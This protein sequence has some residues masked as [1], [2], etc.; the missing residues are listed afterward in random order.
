MDDVEKKYLYRRIAGANPHLVLERMRV[1]G[2]WPVGKGLPPAPPEEVEERKKID[3]ELE[4][5]RAR[6]AGKGSAADVELALREERKRRWEESKKR[7]SE[8]KKLREARAAERRA[9]WNKQKKGLLVFA[10]EGV[11]AG[12]RGLESDAAALAKRGLPVLHTPPELAAAIGISI[13][14]L[15]WL[16]FHRGGAMLVHY[17]RY[18]IPKKSGGIRAISA[19]KPALAKAQQ[20]VLAS[21]LARLGTEPAAHGFVPERSI[22]SNAT[23]HVGK[24]VVV[25][26]DLKDFFP[27][28]TFPR[29]KGLFESF[30]YGSAV[31]TCLALLCTEPPRV[32]LELD[33]R[34]LSV[35]LGAR[36]LPQGACTSPAITNLVCR[37]LDRRLAG[38]AEKFG[39]TYTRYADDLTFSRATGDGVG[40]LLHHVRAILA[41]EGFVENPKK[42][43]V[44]RRGRRQEVTGVTVNTKPGV[45]RRELRQLRAIL[46]NAARDGLASQNR[47]GHPH[48]AA[49][50]RGRVA[51][52]TMVDPSKREELHA[53]LARA[54][55]RG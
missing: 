54:L 50:L 49:Y 48:F 5:L 33:G 27:T 13:G 47:E 42:T 34:A 12:L 30:G 21:V 31:A 23:P 51:F 2:F 25:N 16:T 19:P 17:H 9:E 37:R 22:V 32:A 6:S 10:G 45:S 52:V 44:M 3:A 1:H 38:L 28:L 18:G 4:A 7:R 8:K 53:A 36:V 24:A 15:R 26:L 35:A 20:W 40:G 39:F 43:H 55:A 46:H 29:V 11:S 41:E 14:R